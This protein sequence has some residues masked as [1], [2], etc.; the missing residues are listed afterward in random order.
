MSLTVDPK[1]WAKLYKPEKNPVAGKPFALTVDVINV[2]PSDL[3][4]NITD[5][6]GRPLPKTVRDLGI[7][8]FAVEFT[9]AEKGGL[10]VDIK[11]EGKPIEGSPLRLDVRRLFY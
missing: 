9:P 7:G 11:L 3:D 4:I 1:P 6:G 8:Q 5:A 10:N 2:K